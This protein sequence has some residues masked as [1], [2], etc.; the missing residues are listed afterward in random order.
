MDPIHDIYQ[1]TIPS[2]GKRKSAYSKSSGTSSDG[3]TEKEYTA[4]SGL[5]TTTDECTEGK[6]R[7]TGTPCA[8]NNILSAIVEFAN[9]VEASAVDKAEEAHTDTLPTA[10]DPESRAVRVSASALGCQSESCILTHPSLR[11]FVISRK[12]ASARELD[13]ELKINYKTKGPR[14]TVDLLSNYNIDETLQR[15]AR[16]Y[17]NFYPCPFAMMDFATNGD[18]FGEADLP[19][20]IEGKI[21]VDLGTERVRRPADCFGCVVNTDN[22]TG[23]GKHWVAVFVD[24]RP[25]PGTPW[26]VEYFNSVGRPPPKPMVKWMEVTR[27]HLAMYRKDIVRTVAVTDVD[28]QESRTECGLYSLFYIRRRIEDTPYTFFSGRRVPDSA[29][30]KFRQH[31]FRSGV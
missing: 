21:P 18:Y 16:D 13:N 7:I 1:Y 11:E 20:I 27:A 3:K 2:G 23:P 5:A 24:C 15:W 6:N 31:I 19:A 25:P 4:L 14:N 22:S 17:T 30:T 10:D 26:T 8:Q 12:L 28:H 9:V 29:M